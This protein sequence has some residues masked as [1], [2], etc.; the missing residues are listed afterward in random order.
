MDHAYTDTAQVVNFTPDDTFS[1]FVNR[2]VVTGESLNYTEV[3]YNE[4]RITGL[5]GTV[6]WWG[7]K[8]DKKVWYSDDKTRRVRFPRL[9]VLESTSSILFQLAGDVSEGI[10]EIDADDQYCVVEISAPNLIPLLMSAIAGYLAAGQISDWVYVNVSV[11]V[12]KGWTFPLGRALENTA[13][14][15]ALMVLGSSGNYQYELYGRP[16]GYVRR[17]VSGQADDTDL[18]QRIGTVV[19]N[20]IEG[21]L[22]DTAARCTDVAELE[23]MLATLQRSRAKLTKTAHL[24]DQEGDTITFPHPHTGNTV[25][26]FVTDLKRRYLPTKDGHFLDEIEGWV[27]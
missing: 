15:L 25:T 11:G 24:Q 17:S 14:V 12:G 8:K 5:S 13:I 16:V 26:M 4:E 2:I 18:Q 3:L 6:G 10:E 22:C 21:F 23:L 20:K 27:L 9:E 1:D 19:A 7:F